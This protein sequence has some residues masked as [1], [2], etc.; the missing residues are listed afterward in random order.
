[1]NAMEATDQSPET[2]LGT[3]GQNLGATSHEPRAMTLEL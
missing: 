1:M 3:I 2:F